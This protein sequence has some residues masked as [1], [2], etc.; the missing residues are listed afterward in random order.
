MPKFKA[1]DPD[2]TPPTLERSEEPS[3]RDL[4]RPIPIDWLGPNP[5]QPR[6]RPLAEDEAIDALAEA[7]R[8]S[9]FGG[10]LEARHD[11]RDPQGKLQI[12]SGHRRLE[13][14][15]RAGL[16]TIPVRI[17]EYTDEEMGTGALRENLLRKDLTPWEEA[18]ALQRLRDRGKTYDEISKIVLRSKGWLQ[19]RLQLLKLEGPLREAAMAHPEMMTVLN[20]LLLLEPDARQSLFDRV[21]T[22]ELNVEDLRALVRAKREAERRREQA[23]LPG[24]G[25]RID[26]PLAQQSTSAT[27]D[28]PEPGS[29]QTPGPGTRRR[30]SRPRQIDRHGKSPGGPPPTTGEPPL[31]PEAANA[32]A[33]AGLA[34]G[35]VA[36]R[37]LVA[38]PEF[39][40]LTPEERRAFRD[41]IQAIIDLLDPLT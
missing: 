1:N 22:G 24:G 41:D 16:A 5:F 17:V 38:R 31:S 32:R 26:V 28:R 3:D 36:L 20:I 12:V 21:R 37:R 7:M 15:R 18:V 9:G 14:A 23:I 29:P 10:S 35:L 33:M 4:P 25:M 2:P 40:A 6:L 39:A 8:Q 27:P 13:A 11:P 30:T 34:V 19:N